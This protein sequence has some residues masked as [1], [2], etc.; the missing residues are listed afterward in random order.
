MQLDVP[1]AA[2]FSAQLRNF[3]TAMNW[4]LPRD[5]DT[6]PSSRVASD[7]LDLD[8]YTFLD[9]VSKIIILDQLEFPMIEVC[10]MI[11]HVCSGFILFHYHFVH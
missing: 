6:L 9:T 1:D 8:A 2:T 5:I 11:Q 4:A 7:S 10:C 3:A